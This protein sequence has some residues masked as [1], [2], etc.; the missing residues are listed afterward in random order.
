LA[1][2]PGKL[3]LC[4][5][6]VQP[7]RHL[8]SHAFVHRGE[9]DEQ[10]GQ[11]DDRDQGVV[12][13]ASD[14]NHRPSSPFLT[15]ANAVPARAGRVGRRYRAESTGFP[16]LAPRGTGAVFHFV[17]GASHTKFGVT[18]T[19]VRM[20]LRERAVTRRPCTVPHVRR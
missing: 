1:A 5:I 8:V 6:A 2:A 9:H 15:L 13:G 17:T 16:A 3:G 19:N 11:G 12:D 7:Q 4:A 14:V 20:G 10:D 18:V